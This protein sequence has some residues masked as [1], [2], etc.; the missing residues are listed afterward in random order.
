[1]AHRTF[2]D[3][4][5]RT[6]DVWHVQPTM[7][8]RRSTPPES[9]VGMERRKHSEPRAPL[10]PELMDGWLAF[11][12]RSERRRLTPPPPNWDDMHD[13]ELVELLGS[14]AVVAK[15]RRRLIE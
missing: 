1:M 7:A 6:W 14:A 5:G 11:E 9:H 10:P 15:V 4:D 8:E 12:S 3:R 13:E 2:R